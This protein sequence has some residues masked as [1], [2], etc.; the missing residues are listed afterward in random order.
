[1]FRLCCRFG[2]SADIDAVV[3]S[4]LIGRRRSCGVILRIHAVKVCIDLVLIVN[5]IDRIVVVIVLID[6]VVVRVD[7]VVLVILVVLIDCVVVVLIDLEPLQ[8]VE[9]VCMAF[10]RCCHCRSRAVVVP[11][12]GRA[13]HGGRLLLRGTWGRR[14]EGG[15]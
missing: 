8:L 9:A 15:R 5:F 1:M 2:I 10:T 12:T 3:C 13:A 6:R 4:T 11:Q 14:V 7:R